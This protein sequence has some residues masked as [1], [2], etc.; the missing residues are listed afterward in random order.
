MVKKK[1]IYFI[2]ILIKSEST[3]KTIKSYDIICFSLSSVK[4]IR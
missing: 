4:K 1:T 2:I 3:N